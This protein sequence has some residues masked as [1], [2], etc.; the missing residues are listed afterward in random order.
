MD[1]KIYQ[2]KEISKPRQS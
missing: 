2:S 1:S